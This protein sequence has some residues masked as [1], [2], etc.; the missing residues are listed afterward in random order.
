M[1]TSLYQPR[2]HVITQIHAHTQENYLEHFELRVSKSLTLSVQPLMF[3]SSIK[4]VS[5]KHQRLS[6]G[7]YLR[8]KKGGSS[9]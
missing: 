5:C 3:M 2:T 7:V 1:A 6:A 8:D 9:P 4:I